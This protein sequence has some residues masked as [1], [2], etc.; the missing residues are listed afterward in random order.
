ML[1]VEDFLFPIMVLA[2]RSGTKNEFLSLEKP[3]KWVAVVWVWP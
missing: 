3:K 1:I 2:S